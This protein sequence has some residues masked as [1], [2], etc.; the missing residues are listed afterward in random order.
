MTAAG[1]GM[2]NIQPWDRHGFVNTCVNA[3]IVRAEPTTS[4]LNDRGHEQR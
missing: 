4:G 2:S 3:R 1:Q